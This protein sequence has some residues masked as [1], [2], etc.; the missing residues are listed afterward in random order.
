MKFIKIA[1]ASAALFLV[2]GCVTYPYQS[3]FD[4]CDAEAGACYRYCEEVSYSDRD[5][6]S[7]HADCE[8]GANR[9]FAESYD[10]YSYSGA[11]YAPSWPWY[12]RYGAWGPSSGYYFDFSYW[13][14]SGRYYDPYYQDRHRYNGRRGRDRDR[15]YP[16]GRDRDGKDG[17]P[18]GGAYAPPSG[19]PAAQNPNR[20]RQP[21]NGKPRGPGET[22]YTQTE[23]RRA[24]PLQRKQAVPQS[25]APAQAAPTQ[26]A[27]VQSA[28]PAASPRQQQPVRS[29]PPS[30]SRHKSGSPRSKEQPQDY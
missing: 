28:P 11:S 15:D 13:S 18:G 23:K 2:A 14:G 12:G 25:S 7:C 30:K 27:P 22:P 6:A 16:R 17:K 8:V 5:Y 24:P 3:A 19:S 9:C 29:N 10:R 20:P 26:S 4:T 1:L 21:P